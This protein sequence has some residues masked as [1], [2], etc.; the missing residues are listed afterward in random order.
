[1]RND[2]IIKSFNKFLPLLVW[3]L[4]LTKLMAYYSWSALKDYSCLTWRQY[5]IPGIKTWSAKS[6][7][8]VLPTSLSLL[9]LILFN[10]S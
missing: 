6:K 9:I 3:G 10:S 5:G 8:D 4:Y 1:M 2:Y 7:A